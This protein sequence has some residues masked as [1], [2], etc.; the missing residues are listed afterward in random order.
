MNTTDT[1]LYDQGQT[2]GQQKVSVLDW[3]AVAPWA[4]LIFVIYAIIF[5]VA[6]LTLSLVQIRQVNTSIYNDLIANLEQRDRDGD[7]E[8]GLP[9]VLTQVSEQ[10]AKYSKMMARAARCIDLDG[11]I[12]DNEH[13]NQDRISV[14]D[15]QN[16]DKK[17]KQQPFSCNNIQNTIKNHKNGLLITEDNARF[18]LAHNDE[19]YSQYIAG[20]TQQM[21]QIIPA[22]RFLDSKQS[23]ISSWAR[24]S[25]ELMEMVLLVSMGMLGGIINATRWLVD[26]SVSRSSLFA[27]FYKPAV[28]GAIALGAFVVFRATQLIIGGQVQNGAVTVTASIYLLAGLGLVS[29]FCADKVLRQIEKAADGLVHS[30]T[31]SSAKVPDPIDHATVPVH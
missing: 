21:P 14:A 17:P 29:G 2:P 6:L 7:E 12:L 4:I 13:D 9:Y 10:R 25:V 26:R 3:R 20:I 5:A 19:W 11:I 30:A 23:W 16:G 18:K 1:T 24:S 15:K 8:R 22:L 28:G 27:Y 31:S